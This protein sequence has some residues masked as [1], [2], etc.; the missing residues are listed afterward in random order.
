MLLCKL[1]RVLNLVNNSVVGQF[2]LG[3][4]G[5]PGFRLRDLAWQLEAPY[6]D[7]VKTKI[8]ELIPQLSPSTGFRLYLRSELARRLSSNPQY[9]LRSF[10]LQLGINHSTLSQLLRGK[11]ALTPRMIKTLGARLGLRPEEIE[12]FVARERQAGETVVSR[13]IRFLTMETVALLSDGSHRAILEMTS[14]EG[15]VPDTRWIARALDLTVDEVNMALSRLTR[16]GLL[17]MV[18]VDRWVDRSEAGASSDAG[19]AQQVI[20]RLSEQA[21]RLSGAKD[22]EATT[23]AARIE[24]GAAQL[25][26]VISLIEK[27][28]HEAADLRRGEKE[29]QLEIYLSPIKLEQI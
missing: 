26:A 29:Y 7:S 14:M 28:Q 1:F 27:L 20:H 3:Q 16:L 4:S 5:C 9:S 13:E 15:F 18:A 21:R 17:E 22:E 24:M 11:R 19:F 6:Y 23:P 2:C 25:P 12:A 10:A 8:N